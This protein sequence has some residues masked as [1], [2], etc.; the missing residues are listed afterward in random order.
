MQESQSGGVRFRPIGMEEPSSS[1]RDERPSER[2]H[3]DGDLLCVQREKRPFSMSER[4][5]GALDVFASRPSQWTMGG[6]Y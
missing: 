2:K 4:C 3:N 1:D 5:G 6:L